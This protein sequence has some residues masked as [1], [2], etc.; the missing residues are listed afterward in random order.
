VSNEILSGQF[1]G[2]HP[3]GED[4]SPLKKCGH[5]PSTLN[6]PI[7]TGLT[8]K[9]SELFWSA[10]IQ[11]LVLQIRYTI[12]E[13]LYHLQSFGASILT[14]SDRTAASVRDIVSP[15]LR[16]LARTI[17]SVQKSD[18]YCCKSMKK[19]RSKVPT[20]TRQSDLPLDTQK[21]EP[22]FL[23]RRCFPPRWPPS[24]SG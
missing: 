9:R 7:V 5:D 10:A 24:V 18:W 23:V 15:I 8:I 21:G 1:Q 13:A 17:V 4:Q 19:V 12:M 20:L 16:R 11:Y 14:A 6:C 22:E 3:D 2:I